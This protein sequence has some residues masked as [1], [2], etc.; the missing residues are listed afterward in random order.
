MTFLWAK[1][2]FMMPRESALINSFILT[3]NQ[4]TTKE[5]AC[6]NKPAQTYH[7]QSDMDCN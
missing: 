3:M 7:E 6:S 5:G 2:E 4:M 1:A